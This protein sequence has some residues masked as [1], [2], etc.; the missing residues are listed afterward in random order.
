M[1]GSS[2]QSGQHLSAPGS[3]G[4]GEADQ[5]G[6]EVGA[7][8][9]VAQ[10]EVGPP[11]EAEAQ[12]NIGT[13]MRYA[14]NLSEEESSPNTPP[15]VILGPDVP[16][17]LLSYVDTWE[18]CSLVP[19]PDHQSV[20]EAGPSGLQAP[21]CNDSPPPTFRT[22]HRSLQARVGAAGLHHVLNPN[23]SWDTLIVESRGR[24][25]SREDRA[26]NMLC[27]VKPTY[28][29]YVNL[30]DISLS[31]TSSSAPSTTHSGHDEDPLQD[32]IGRAHV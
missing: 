24:P 8:E 7:A 11:P 21:V 32:Q 9:A 22:L 2:S 15:N 10:I 12:I 25:V 31:N 14:L 26:R 5:A 13:L 30:L 23:T 4:V 27:Y 18:P 3:G 16:L 20:G 1:S 29:S 19:A 17:D 6:E 28:S